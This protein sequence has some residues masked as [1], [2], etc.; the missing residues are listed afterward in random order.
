MAPLYPYHLRD[1]LE[2]HVGVKWMGE[3]D[4]WEKERSRL[5]RVGF[6]MFSDQVS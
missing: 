4:R 2:E 3:K 6:I 1:R 5:I